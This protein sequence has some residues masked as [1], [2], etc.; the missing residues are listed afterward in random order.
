[1]LRIE[2]TATTAPRLLGHLGVTR[3]EGKFGFTVAMEES[4]CALQIFFAM[5]KFETRL[6]KSKAHVFEA[7]GLGEQAHWAHPFV[8]HSTFF[9]Q[10]LYFMFFFEIFF[11]QGELSSAGICLWHSLGCSYSSLPSNFTR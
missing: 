5:T 1:M 6:K 2:P 7:C 4:R 10:F 11:L 8:D 9:I 3:D